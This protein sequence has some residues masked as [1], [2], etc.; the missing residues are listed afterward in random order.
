MYRLRNQNVQHPTWK[1]QRIPLSKKLVVRQDSF[2]LNSEPDS[3]VKN[4][5]AWNIHFKHLPQK[6]NTV[7][8]GISTESQKL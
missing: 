8:Y 2:T 1:L 3:S 4:N 6:G 7:Y 5:S